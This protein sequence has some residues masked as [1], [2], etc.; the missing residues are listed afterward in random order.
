VTK[1]AKVT[2]TTLATGDVYKQLGQISQEARFS[3]PGLGELPIAYV[4]HRQKPALGIVPAW[5]ADWVA[6]H[7]DEL[8]AAY[9]AANPE[10][11]GS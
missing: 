10:S 7:A 3:R 6:E 1:D 5:V 11:A 8:I 4:L 9:R 2:T